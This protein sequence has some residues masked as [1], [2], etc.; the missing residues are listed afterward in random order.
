MLNVGLSAVRFSGKTCT[1]TVL[2]NIFTSTSSD[3]AY[4]NTVNEVDR[5]TYP[6]NSKAALKIVGSVLY[7]GNELTLDATGYPVINLNDRDAAFIKN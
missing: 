6:D 7:V 5:F 3:I 1:G 2:P 4:F